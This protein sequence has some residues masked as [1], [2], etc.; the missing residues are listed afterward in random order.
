MNDADANANAR[1]DAMRTAPRA[2]G[3]ATFYVIVLTVFA[4]DQM[5]KA[6]MQKTLFWE[7]SRPIFGESFLL[8]LT[9]NTGGAW[10]ML[11]HGN[12][13]FIGFAIAAVFALLFAYYRMAKV[14]LFVGA[15]FALALGGA[16][17]NLLDR[18]RYGY[19][20]D[21][22]EARIIHWPIFNVADSAITLGIVLLLWHFFR[23]ARTEEETPR[24][25][26]ALSL[27]TEETGTRSSETN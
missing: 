15:A 19:V 12:S 2:L 22:F 6:W 18:L 26:Q 13:L 23:A 27:A 3:P 11:P 10:G 25:T 16:L 17:G 9:R 24:S 14:E 7:Q 21:F 1:I 5:T 4:A 8:T 20:V